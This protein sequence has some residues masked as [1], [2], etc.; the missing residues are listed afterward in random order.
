M[1]LRYEC[2][3]DYVYF[4]MQELDENNGYTLLELK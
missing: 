3:D 1:E 4:D 2:D